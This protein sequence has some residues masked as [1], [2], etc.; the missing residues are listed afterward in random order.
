M[1]SIL[2]IIE[3]MTQ[4]GGFVEWWGDKFLSSNIVYTNSQEPMLHGKNS[5]VL[6]FG[7]LFNMKDNDQIVTVK[8]MES[9]I[10]EEWFTQ[11][12]YW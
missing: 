3:Y 1:L 4:H 7:F 8:E 10:K 9:F 5:T 6:T 12:P 2:E 11:M